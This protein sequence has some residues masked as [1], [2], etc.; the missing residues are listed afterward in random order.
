MGNF[1]HF[2]KNLATP[3]TTEFIFRKGEKNL[4]KPKNIG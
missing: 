3:S 2:L 1:A 4:L